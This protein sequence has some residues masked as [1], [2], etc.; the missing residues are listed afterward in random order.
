MIAVPDF[1]TLTAAEQEQRMRRLADRAIAR[2]HGDWTVGRL[3]IHRENAVFEAKAADGRRAALRIHRAGYHSDASLRSELVWMASLGD[4]GLQVPA[5]I[6]PAGGAPFLIAA[7]EDVPAPRQVDLL[8]WLDGR[9]VGEVE[10]SRLPSIYFDA[11]A[12]AAQL[13]GH[14][15]AWPLPAEFV[16]H[17]WD[18]DG[19]IGPAPLWGGYAALSTLQHDERD[20]LD[21]ARSAAAPALAAIGQ[22]GDRYG[23]I[24]ADLVPE[25]LLWDEAGLKLIDFDDSGFGWHMFELATALFFHLD[26]PDYPAIEQALFAGYASVRPLGAA[27]RAQLPLFLMLRGF[28]YLGWVGTRSETETARTLTPMMIART[29]GLAAAFLGERS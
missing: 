23:L 5:L 14:S 19:L 20:L 1:A 7:H 4:A 11:G 16:R 27:M 12:L 15:A 22:D 9:P 25:N 6:P 24:H 21:R 18:A 3:I 28:T 26:E 29:C 17:S 10:R 2:W 8:G 13:H